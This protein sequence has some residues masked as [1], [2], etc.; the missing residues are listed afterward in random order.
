MGVIFSGDLF[1]IKCIL[2]SFLPFKALMFVKVESLISF[3][4]KK[5]ATLLSIVGL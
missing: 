2:G 5:S 4:S 3:Y 1:I